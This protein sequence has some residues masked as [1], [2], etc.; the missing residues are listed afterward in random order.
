MLRI[1]LIVLLAMA[2]AI[3]FGELRWRINSRQR[4]QQIYVARVPIQPTKFD[5]AELSKLPAPVQ[6]YFRIALKDSQPMIKAAHL[7]HSGTFN[8][9]DTAEQWKLFTSTQLVTARRCGFDWD[10][11]IVMM[12]GVPVLVHDSYVNGKGILQASVFGLISVA[13]MRGTADMAQG[14]LMRFLAEAAWYP[15][16]L[17]PSQGV[18]WQAV[19]DLSARA[20]LTDGAVSATL[21]FQF[22]AEGLIDLVSAETRARVVDGITQYTPWQGRFWNYTVHDGMRIPL[23][24]EVEW[25]LPDG[26]RMPYWRGHLTTISH[27]FAL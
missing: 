24:G 18:I 7:T 4:R 9:S 5:P 14:E 21:L 15:T 8:M 13:S 22:N 6:R 20:T 26:R 12:P 1:A 11:R 10:A 2:A 25:L 17:L 19:D 23:D 3:F 16:A 27:E